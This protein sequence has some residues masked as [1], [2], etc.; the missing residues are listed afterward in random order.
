[1]FKVAIAIPAY[2]EEDTIGHV[3]IKAKSAVSKLDAFILV[4]DDGSSDRTAELAERAGA[5]VIIRHKNNRGVSCAYNSCI[6]YAV[7][8]GADIICTIDADGQFSPEEIPKMISPIK[9]KM[10]DIAIGSRFIK[11]S[12]NTQIPILN[13]VTNKIIAR[14]VGLLI[15]K[16]LYDVESGFRAYSYEAAMKL[17]LMG[18]GSFSYDT[19]LDLSSKGFRI[20]EVPVSVKY[21]KNRNSRVVSSL[22]RYGVTSFLSIILKLLTI[23]KLCSF[24]LIDNFSENSVY[25]SM[26]LLKHPDSIL[27]EQIK[28]RLLQQK[29]KTNNLARQ[30]EMK[31]PA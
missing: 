13:S 19:I 10:C 25:K 2:N 20:H 22:L 26:P 29:D 14:F 5:D 28:H 3:I 12:T 15:K 17:D 21:F 18:R 30:D 1:M 24:S 4:V 7:K 27:I 6:K 16:R 9:T 23:R 8:Y 31:M 11:P